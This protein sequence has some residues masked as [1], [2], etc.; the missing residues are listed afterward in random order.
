MIT[1]ILAAKRAARSGTSTVIAC[2]REPDIL[3]RLA[4]GESIGTE[5]SAQ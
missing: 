5:L 2:G 3:R 4:K 1:K